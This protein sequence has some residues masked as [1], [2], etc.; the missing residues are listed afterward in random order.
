MRSFAEMLGDV[1]DPGV[2]VTHT[3]NFQPSPN[4]EPVG[5]LTGAPP[6]TRAYQARVIPAAAVG[7]DAPTQIVFASREN[8]I[9]LLLAPTVG[10]TIYV[11]DEGVTPNTGFPLPAGQPWEVPLVGRQALYAVTDS[12]VFLRLGVQVSTVLL[13]DRERK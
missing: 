6:R 4:S 12:P 10:F 8:R 11:G 7:Q 1:G 2:G 3:P 9:A 5:A 13:A